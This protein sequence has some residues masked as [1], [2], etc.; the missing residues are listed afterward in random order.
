M[1]KAD[2]YDSYKYSAKKKAEKVSDTNYVQ[3]LSSSAESDHIVF[4]YG[5]H[6]I[7]AKINTSTAI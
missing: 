7:L 1:V 4:L 2:W 5:L 3:V 6:K